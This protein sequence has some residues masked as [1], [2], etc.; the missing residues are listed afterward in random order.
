MNLGELRAA[1]QTRQMEWPG[2]DEADVPF[3]ALEVAGE[4]GELFEAVKKFLRAER[5][6]KGSTATKADIADEM[7]DLLISL[8]LLANELDIDLGKATRSKFNATSRKYG[9][10]TVI[11]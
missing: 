6:I 5:G 8:D 9:L 4:A 10:K 1:S 11:S 2:S 3:R 7:G